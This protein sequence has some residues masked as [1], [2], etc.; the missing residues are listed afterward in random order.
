LTENPGFSVELVMQKL[1]IVGCVCMHGKVGFLRYIITCGVHLENPCSEKVYLAVGRL[2]GWF[3]LVDLAW[4]FGFG[5][6]RRRL[7]VF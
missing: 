1:Y 2:N 3:T 7:G 4:W 5:S 6:W